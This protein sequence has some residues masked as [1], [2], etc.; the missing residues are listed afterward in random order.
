[1]VG[2]MSVL[3]VVA[4]G[5]LT[6]VVAL[7]LWAL[8]PAFAGWQ[9][10]VVLSD[11]MAPG[12]RTGDLL[13]TSRPEGRSLVPGQVLLVEHQGEAGR[14]PVRVAHRLVGLDPKGRLV[15]RGDANDSEDAEHVSRQ[16]VLGVGRMLIPTV[17][18]PLAD[19]RLGRPEAAAPWLAGLLAVALL[20]APAGALRCGRLR[21]R[22][23]AGRFVTTV[24]AVACVLSAASVTG[25]TS[26]AFTSSTSRPAG[27]LTASP[28]FYRSA[29]LADS[30]SA[31]FRM[32]DP[33][34]T[35][36]DDSSGA[37]LTGAYRG[38]VT[39]GAAGPLDGAR[40]AAS[41]LGSGSARFGDRFDFAGVA[42]FTLE[43][44][45]RPTVLDEGYRGIFNKRTT[46]NGFPVGWSL[47][48]NAT[49]GLG[50]ERFDGTGGKD[51]ILATA[52]TTNRW[53]HVAATYDGATMCLYQD[54]VQSGCSAATRN[55]SDTVAPLEIGALDSPDYVDGHWKG[56]L[57]D[58]AIYT[59]DLGATRVAAH[60][61]ATTT[62]AYDAAVAVDLPA[63]YW[64]LADSLVRD[65]ADETGAPA[66]T[67]YGAVTA[68][69]A[70]ALASDSDQ[71]MTSGDG[72]ALDTRFAFE[73][74]VPY[75]VE[76]WVR[77]TVVDGEYRNIVRRENSSP[78][79]GWL[80]WHHSSGVGFE[81]FDGAGGQAVIVG[82]ALTVGVWS[83]VAG[84]YD[85]NVLRLYIDGALVAS[86]STTLALPS[87][88]STV[89]SIGYN[90]AWE[91]DSFVGDL[92]EVAIY[93]S[94]LSGTQLA[95]HIAFA[96]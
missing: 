18:R 38:G 91:F 29:V 36:A 52:L 47:W 11:S 66:G 59:S 21:R 90:P 55:V 93:P 67:V 39:D 22:A 12:M 54:G 27:P 80:M 56:E 58:A 64:H 30:P 71:A 26:A 5:V 57:A 50:L 34:D 25:G 94:A 33:V 6:V 23:P 86:M 1:M 46:V 45:V 37:N 65:V 75:T 72:I 24:V 89:T 20:A 40:T 42:P 8:L 16:H 69:V 53:T 85:G 73:G 60:A 81:R 2:L 9:T 7:L 17:G 61:A 32:A 63:A 41:F 78:R 77:P 84:S 83:H 19:L 68:Q 96:Q 87:A 51:V 28:T 48:N 4:R 70:G 44:W 88:A 62:A 92:D 43:A 82:P 13:V 49:Y 14:P 31:Y 79:G 3:R 35:S 95:E 15:T 76:A 10:S 74:R